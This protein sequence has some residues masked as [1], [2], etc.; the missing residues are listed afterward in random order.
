MLE[1][2]FSETIKELKRLEEMVVYFKNIEAEQSNHIDDLKVKIE[3]L[4]SDI[5][6]LQTNEVNTWVLENAV[7]ESIKENDKLKK[8]ISLLTTENLE[9][10]H[11]RLQ[12]TFPNLNNKLQEVIEQNKMLFTKNEHVAK[13]YLEKT[14]EITKLKKENNNLREQISTLKNTVTIKVPK[15]RTHETVKMVLNIDF[16]QQQEKRERCLIINPQP[17]SGNQYRKILQIIPNIESEF[18]QRKQY[19]EY[20]FADDFKIELNTDI[21]NNLTDAGF[22]L[23]ITPKVVYIN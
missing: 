11:D 22:T 16:E 9:L 18:L 15:T 3:E 4:S 7:R 21:V 5:I 6:V 17:I 13:C 12:P 10:K 2:K 14:E 1:D 8:Q 20:Y 19:D 23:K